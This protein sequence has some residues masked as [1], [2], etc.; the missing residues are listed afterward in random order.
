MFLSTI[1]TPKNFYSMLE[2]TPAEI[3]W[4]EKSRWTILDKT[5]VFIFRTRREFWKNCCFL[6]CQL[7]KALFSPICIIWKCNT[8]HS[9]GKSLYSS[10]VKHIIYQL[11]SP[12][13]LSD[14]LKWYEKLAGFFILF[15]IYFCV[16]PCLLGFS[17]QKHLDCFI[18][19]R[20][21]KNWTS[22][23]KRIIDRT[24]W[25]KTHYSM[26]KKFF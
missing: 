25:T 4:F 15:S 7:Q 16:V 5:G 19:S 1:W 12:K 11:N 8:A 18:F 2:T 10:F 23:F 3:G 22:A 26:K 6:L 21:K 9:K 20:M 13:N 14:L 24:F 17:T